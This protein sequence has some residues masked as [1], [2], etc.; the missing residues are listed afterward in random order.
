MGRVEAG[1]VTQALVGPESNNGPVGEVDAECVNLF[2]ADTEADNDNPV[3]FQK[4]HDILNWPA[5]DVPVVTD[6][7]CRLFDIGGLKRLSF[8][9][10]DAR[11]IEVGQRNVFFKLKCEFP[12][13][14]HVGERLLAISGGG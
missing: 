4:S 5:W 2:D 7:G 10:W 11:Q 8:V 14:V 3:H 6:L 13:E 1:T 9:D 12:R